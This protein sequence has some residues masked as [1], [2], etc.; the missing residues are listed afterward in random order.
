VRIATPAPGAN[1]AKPRELHGV[2][3][4]LRLQRSDPF[5]GSDEL[6][7]LLGANMAHE[8]DEQR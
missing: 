3:E 2:V 5:R 7:R 8:G 1:G 6:L 4:Q